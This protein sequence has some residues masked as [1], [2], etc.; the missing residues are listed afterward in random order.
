MRGGGAHVVRVSVSVLGEKI[1]M[2]IVER[3]NKEEEDEG[4]LC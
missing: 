1:L 2:S 4:V 3:V